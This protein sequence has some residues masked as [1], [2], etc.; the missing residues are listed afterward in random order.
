M[1]PG[2]CQIAGLGNTACPLPWDG[3]SRADA[4]TDLFKFVAG[5]PEGANLSYIVRTVFGRDTDLA[6]GDA[7]LARRFFADHPE[8][9]ETARRDGFLWVDPTPAALYLNRRKQ[10][11]K[12]EDCDGLGGRRPRRSP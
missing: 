4:K 7:Q 8:L 1:T 5:T 11:A 10:R 6:G 3:D 2:A 9:F 12:N